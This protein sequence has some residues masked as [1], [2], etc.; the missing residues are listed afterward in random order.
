MIS[1][2]FQKHR[3]NILAANSC[4]FI[5]LI[6]L[7]EAIRNSLGLTPVLNTCYTQVWSH[8]QPAAPCPLPFHWTSPVGPQ[9]FP[10]GL[11]DYRLLLLDVP[12]LPTLSLPPLTQF[13]ILLKVTFMVVLGRRQGPPTPH[14]GQG[15]E[16]LGTH[17]LSFPL[18]TPSFEKRAENWVWIPKVWIQPK[19]L[20][21]SEEPLQQM[22]IAKGSRM[23]RSQG[24]S[25][26]SADEKPHK[27][28]R[29]LSHLPLCFHWSN[30]FSL[31]KATI[32]T[33]SR[34]FAS[35]LEITFELCIRTDKYLRKKSTP[36][37]Q[38]CALSAQMG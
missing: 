5:L 27:E 1:K 7:H 35:V 18:S 23:P 21:F 19:K 30:N 29:D 12:W 38:T 10:L 24:Y 28:K 25:S 6:H 16:L 26:E 34:S 9:L 2:H 32:I 17:G 4:F 8:T 3:Y 33:E 31:L 20:A 36:S 37:S 15:T 13:D 11:P 14:G 22:S